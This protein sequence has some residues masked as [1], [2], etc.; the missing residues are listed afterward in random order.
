MPMKGYEATMFVFG[1]LLLAG[2]ARS[3]NDSSANAADARPAGVNPWATN[4]VDIAR[5]QDEVPFGPVAVVSQD[6]TPVRAAPEEGIVI[7]TLP[8]G[9]Y[10]VKLSRHDNDDLVTFDGPKGG[11]QRLVGWVPE[12]ALADP[13]PPPSASSSP[14]PLPTTPPPSATTAD[15]DGGPPPSPL[16]P[17]PPPGPGPHHHHHRPRP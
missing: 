17:E 15:N 6:H 12:S 10:V 13:T 5:Y 14:P 2:C 3:A 9:A 7:A 8:G 1:T 16:P 4:W 11:G